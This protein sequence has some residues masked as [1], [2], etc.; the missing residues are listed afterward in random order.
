[1]D[2]VRPHG[3]KP[4]LRHSLLATAANSVVNFGTSVALARLCG[5]EVL[6][7]FV[8]VAAWAHL[9][10]ALLS[11][12]FDQAYIQSSNTP[13]RW[14]SAV[15]LSVLQAL[16]LLVAPVLLLFSAKLSIPSAA[17][18]SIDIGAFELVML[19]IVG[20]VFANLLLAP[21]AARLEY[22]TVGWLRLIAAAGASIVSLGVAAVQEAPSILPLLLR[23][24]AAGAFLLLLAAL[25]AKLPPWHG[26]PD[27]GGF[28]EAALFARGLWG[29]VAM[30]KLLQ[31]SEYLLL[32]FVVSTADL[33]VYFAVRSL[34][35]GIYSVVSAP[36]Q[37]VLF[38]HLCRGGQQD[39]ALALFESKSIRNKVLGVIVALT[40]ACAFSPPVLGFIFGAHFV[41]PWPVPA[42]FVVLLCGLVVFELVKVSLMARGTH[43]ALLPA[44]TLQFVLLGTLLPVLGQRFGIA[45]AATAS[46]MAVVGLILWSARTASRQRRQRS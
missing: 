28:L 18:K 10:F 32:G 30:E 37:T 34:F 20:I 3:L 15:W 13:G 6:G 26:T 25:F 42:A 14:E 27:R 38:A 2:P 36:I 45:G 29:L 44:R 35:D 46:A 23:E 5:P 40:I 9:A 4:L 31:R 16:L 1:M 22:R 21:L 43:S 33:G 24:L 7:S 41:P 11:P 12:G 39:A 8:L 19:S 17:L